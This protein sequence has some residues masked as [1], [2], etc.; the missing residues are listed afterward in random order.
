MK[1]INI[2]GLGAISRAKACQIALCDECGA[3]EQVLPVF[4]AIAL[5]LQGYTEKEV[6]QAIFTLHRNGT[7]TRIGQGTYGWSQQD[8]K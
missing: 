8:V 3:D 7:L 1:S 4:A 5:R 2:M 6:R